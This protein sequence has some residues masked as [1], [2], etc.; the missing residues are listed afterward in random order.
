MS[1]TFPAALSRIEAYDTGLASIPTIP[2]AMTYLDIHSCSLSQAAVDDICSQAVV[3]GLS[4][5]TLNFRGNGPIMIS[6]VNTYILTL[7]GLGWTVEYDS[8]V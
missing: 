5:G 4:N 2:A 7:L 8:A 3:G 6:T 1:T